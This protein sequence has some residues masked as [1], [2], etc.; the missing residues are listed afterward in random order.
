MTDEDH[1]AMLKRLALQKRDE[2]KLP[3][4]PKARAWAGRGTG[5]ICV[6]CELPIE[7]GHVEYE[8]EW[9]SAGELRLLRF[10]ELCYRLWSE[11]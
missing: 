9:R 4:L 6:L 5:E 8:V 7:S 3:D 2:G 1:D 10:H 11:P